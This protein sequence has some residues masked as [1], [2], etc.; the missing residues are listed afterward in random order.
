MAKLK[1]PIEKLGT[2]QSP[3]SPDQDSMQEDLE[4]PQEEL[5]ILTG[6]NTGDVPQ[7]D[8]TEAD[9]P[10]YIVNVA[11]EDFNCYYSGQFLTFK[12]GRE[13]GDNTQLLRYLI[14]SGAPLANKLV[15]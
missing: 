5:E 10:E 3:V 6:T 13:I 12:K 1:M 9:L 4:G 15:K 11:A 7:V 8:L 2:E 14:G